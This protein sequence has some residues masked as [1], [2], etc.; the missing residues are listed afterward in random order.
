[1]RW[2]RSGRGPWPSCPPPD[3]QLD[4]G[5]GRMLRLAFLDQPDLLPVLH[6]H[7]GVGQ[8][9]GRPPVSVQTATGGVSRS[10]AEL[11]RARLREVAHAVGPPDA[12]H[13]AVQVVEEALPASDGRLAACLI[14]AGLV[15]QPVH[16][17]ILSRLCRLWRLPS[18]RW[19]VVSR[20]DSSRTLLIR[21]NGRRE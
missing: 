6:A 3:V 19:V 5:L 13:V 16:P 1:M 15:E 7:L 18:P 4:V 9:A 10:Q 17:E 12:L 20:A 8:A 11:L 14:E 2:T 21:G